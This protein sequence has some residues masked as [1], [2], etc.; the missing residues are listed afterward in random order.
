MWVVEWMPDF[1]DPEKQAAII[2]D[3]KSKSQ[4]HYGLTDEQL[5]TVKTADELRILQDA[6]KYRELVANKS[7]AQQ[8]AEGAR[9]VKPAAK[10]AASAGKASKARQATQQMRKS[11]THDDVTN[12]LLS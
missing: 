6:L 5:N 12:W 2:Q 4:K 11:G 8:K 1:A 10:R 7:K 9:P 3:I